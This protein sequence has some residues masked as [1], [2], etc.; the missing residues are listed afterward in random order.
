[1]VF[2]NELKK[3]FSRTTLFIILSVMML[4]GILIVSGEKDRGYSFSAEGYKAL[5]DS[6]EM[7]GDTEAQLAYLE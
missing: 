4:N 1:M 5:Y 7:Q 6:P 3:T 2:W